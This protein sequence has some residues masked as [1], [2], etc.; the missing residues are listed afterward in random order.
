M[1]K[2]RAS[3]QEAS[4]VSEA[5]EAFEKKAVSHFCTVGLGRYLHHRNRTCMAMSP[6]YWHHIL[7]SRGYPCTKSI[8]ALGG[9][10]SY[11]N[12]HC[13]HT[14]PKTRSLVRPW[15]C[16]VHLYVPR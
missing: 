10:N 15:Q 5:C 13:P 6:P 3:G 11:W 1:N 12:L 2:T 9:V 14:R 16:D 8:S 7:P 4:R